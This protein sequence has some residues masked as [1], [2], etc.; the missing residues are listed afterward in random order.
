MHEWKSHQFAGK[1]ETADLWD[2]P[3]RP[4]AGGMLSHPS[5]QT[6]ARMEDIPSRTKL[7][8]SPMFNYATDRILAIL[9]ERIE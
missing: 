1:L 5:L 7:K 4:N 2:F 8:S 6:A 3:G 9:L